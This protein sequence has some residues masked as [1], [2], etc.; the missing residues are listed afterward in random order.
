MTLII[1]DWVSPQAD[2]EKPDE[3]DYE[4][5]G[6]KL[7]KTSANLLRGPQTKVASSM[8]GKSSSANFTGASDSMLIG[9]EYRRSGGFGVRRLVVFSLFLIGFTVCVTSLFCIIF[10]PT[11]VS[12]QISKVS[13]GM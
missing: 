1:N 9:Q 2:A 5:N 12:N 4:Q 8:S 13:G 6:K 11:F 3:R 7:G 10:L